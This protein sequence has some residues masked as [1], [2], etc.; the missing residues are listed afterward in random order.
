MN[1]RRR[2]WR[3]SITEA[4]LK[5]LPHHNAVT[6][7]LPQPIRSLALSF[8]SKDTVLAVSPAAPCYCLTAWALDQR[9]WTVGSG[10]VQVA[11][12]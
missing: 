5:A 11:A 7:G 12:D 1:C 4:L 2:G 10:V 6:F 8:D 3:D 9:W